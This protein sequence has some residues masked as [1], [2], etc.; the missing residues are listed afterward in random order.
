MP[1]RDVGVADTTTSAT[2]VGI[3][4]VERASPDLTTTTTADPGTSGTTLAV[5]ATTKHPGTNNFKVDVVGTS[6]IAER[7]LVTAGAGTASYTVTRGQDGTTGV[8]HSIGAKV[9][10]VTAVQRVEPVEATKQISFKGRAVTFRT[11]GRAGTSGQKIFAIHNAT[12][13]PTIVDVHKI[14]V[15]LAATVIKA[16]TVLPPIIR[17]YRFTAVPTNGTALTKNAEDTSLTSKVA[18][19]VWGDAS[20]DGTLSASALTIGAVT[21]GTQTGLLTQEFSPRLITAAGYEMADRMVY[22]E[23]EDETITLRP[24]EG[25]VVFLDYV[26]TTQ[27]VSTDMWTVGCRYT[28]WTQA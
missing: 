15:D 25:L 22:L 8:A 16:V 23:G 1:T 5:I 17:I 24:L 27:N 2:V 6:G 18:V 4:T 3:D 11:P 13:S 12:A 26:L 28:E 19:T 14:T 10:L 20:A 9:A 7:M 21:V